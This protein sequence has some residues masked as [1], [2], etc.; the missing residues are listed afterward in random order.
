MKHEKNNFLLLGS[1]WFP[2]TTTNYSRS[3]FGSRYTLGCCGHAGLFRKRPASICHIASL[4]TNTCPAR[5]VTSTLLLFA[6]CTCMW[7]CGVSQCK[8]T[9][10][11]PCLDPPRTKAILAQ[12]TFFENG[13]ITDDQHFSCQPEPAPR[14]SCA[15]PSQLALWSPCRSQSWLRWAPQLCNS[16]YW[17]QCSPPHRSQT[18]SERERVGQKY[19]TPNTTSRLWHKH[20]DAPVLKKPNIMSE[21]DWLS[22]I[23]IC[24]RS[25]T[26][27]SG[28][29]CWRYWYN[30]KMDLQPPW[31]SIA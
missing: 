27:V 28:K 24:F 29:C 16:T 19:P 14:P 11:L 22:C 6:P 7:S 10:V 2:T 26:E 5:T 8:T 20:C 23:E 13:C 9:G 31:R 17:I 30:K 3:H 4:L 25:R 21:S 15:R 18:P 1:S 12:G